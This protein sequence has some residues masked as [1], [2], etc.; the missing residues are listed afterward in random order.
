MSAT[1]PKD[2][3]VLRVAMKYVTFRTCMLP[4]YSGA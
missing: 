2:G 4:K 1:R 3:T